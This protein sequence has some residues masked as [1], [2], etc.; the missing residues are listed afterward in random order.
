VGA[1]NV[2]SGHPGGGAGA[3]IDSGSSGNH[4]EGNRIGTNAAGTA[5]IPNGIGVVTSA[6]GNFI[7]GAAP[8]AGNLI[9]GNSG[10]FGIGVFLRGNSDNNVVQGNR[11]GTDVTGVNPLPNSGGSGAGVDII[12]GSDNNLIG[13][14][15]TGE[16]NI[17]AFNSRGVGIGSGAG[18]SILGNAIF[19]N[20]QLGID[21][22]EDG[23]TANDTGDAD[24]G[25]N[26]LQN[27]PVLTAT[28]VGPTQATVSG[29]IEQP[30]LSVVSHRDLCQ[31]R[32]GL[33]W[34]W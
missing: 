2:I 26:N 6:P 15:G 14:T 5:A 18:N 29:T 30:P 7:G 11:I 27:F 25:P 8:G 24:T 23:L 19:R 34:L 22:G 16:G 20:S 33:I 3:V 4:I 21:L 28:V 10:F 32:S 13:G 1:A 12:E 9:S 17:V 31:R